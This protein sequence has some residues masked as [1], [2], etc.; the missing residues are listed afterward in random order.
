MRSGLLKSSN[1]IVPT[2]PGERKNICKFHLT[3]N[4]V[5]KT[6]ISA[7]G[8]L[9]KNHVFDLHSKYSQ[10]MHKMKNK[11]IYLYFLLFLTKC[12]PHHN[13]NQF[14]EMFFG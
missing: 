14:V 9:A 6:R 3:F 2:S 11:W 8:F 5:S 1:E 12:L 10:D 13:T 7:I 4:K